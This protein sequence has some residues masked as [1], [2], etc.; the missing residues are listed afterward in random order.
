MADYPRFLVEG[1]FDKDVMEQRRQRLST[2]LKRKDPWKVRVGP[3]LVAKRQSSQGGAAM[4]HLRTYGPPPAPKDDQYEA[5]WGEK[6][7]TWSASLPVGLD[8]LPSARAGAL[9]D[10]YAGKPR[11]HADTYYTRLSYCLP[12]Y[13]AHLA[14]GHAPVCLPSPGGGGPPVRG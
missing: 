6:K 11:P 9:L 13:A 10:P 12:D 7:S 4:A 8:A 3:G 2:R 1:V 5:Y 14:S